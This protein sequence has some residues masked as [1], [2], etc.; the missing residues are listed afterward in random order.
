MI[1]TLESK[2]C[3]NHSKIIKFLFSSVT[4]WHG[5]L[6]KVKLKNHNPKINQKKTMKKNPKNKQKKMKSKNQEMD[7]LKK[8][9][10]V[11]KQKKNKNKKNQSN[12]PSLKIPITL[13]EPHSKNMPILKKLK[14]KF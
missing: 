2:R 14:I 11:I 1:S 4:S 12:I 13:I 8:K 5:A 6:A 9:A 7:Q 10:A 3:L